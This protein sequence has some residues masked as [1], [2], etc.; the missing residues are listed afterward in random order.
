M[1]KELKKEAKVWTVPAKK[2]K[3]KKKKKTKETSNLVNFNV[4]LHSGISDHV[5]LEIR[6]TEY[7]G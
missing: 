5:C 4:N 6:Y 1:T 3:F 7:L 2:D